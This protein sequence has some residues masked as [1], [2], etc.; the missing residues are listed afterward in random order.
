MDHWNTRGL[1]KFTSQIKWS[2]LFFFLLFYKFSW[3][4]NFIYGLNV[5][6]ERNLKTILFLSWTEL[7]V[8]GL[9]VYDTI[10]KMTFSIFNIYNVCQQRISVFD[11]S[12]SP[13]CHILILLISLWLFESWQKLLLWIK[14]RELKKVN[15]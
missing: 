9:S 14:I 1:G 11:H 3:A 4:L 15:K 6:C 10:S 5:T 7:G 2:S 12:L 8:I 13:V